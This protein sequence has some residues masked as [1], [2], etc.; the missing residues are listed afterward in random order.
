MVGTATSSFTVTAS[1]QTQASAATGT[2]DQPLAV[3]LQGTDTDGT[4]ASFVIVSLAAHGTLY[5]EAGFTTQ[6]QIGDTIVAAANAATVYFVPEQD[7]NGATSF[8]FAAVDDLGAQD[9]NPATADLTIA[10]VNDAPVVANIIPDQPS[11]P[12]A[13]WSFTIPAG[14]FTDVDNATLTYTAALANGNPLPGLLSFDAATHTFTG[15]PPRGF[16]GA[17]DI[18]VTVSDGFH[19]ASD[20]F[21]F[22]VPATSASPLDLSQ[23]PDSYHAGNTGE[24]ING[25]GG[26]D[27][28]TVGLGND[29]IDGGLGIDTAVF[30]GL[31]SA[32]TLTRAGNTLTVSGPDGIDMLTKIEKLAFDDVTIPSG[33]T[34]APTDFSADSFGDL[35]WQNDNGQ[36]HIWSMNSTAIASQLNAGGNPGPSWH[37]KASGDFNAD[38]MADILWQNDSGQ[39]A[40]WLMNGSTQVGGGTVGA[41]PGPAWHVKAAADFNG[42]GKADILWQNDNGQAHIWFMDGTNTV[43]QQNAGGSPGASWHI[44]DAADFNGDGKADILWQNDSGQAAIWLMNGST[45]VGGGTVGTNPGPAWHIKSAADFNGDGNADI[46]W[47]HDNGQAHIWFMNG[48]NITGQVN[49]GNNN[50]GPSWHVQDASDINGDGLADIVWQN[51][52]SQAAIWLMNGSSQIGGGTVGA[53]PGTDWH[54]IA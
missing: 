32:Y 24:T 50:P 26:S 51:D 31:R 20:N 47:Q 7:W 35:L 48:T 1:P 30:S 29:T 43:S 36:A 44:I 23:N 17:L 37:V 34:S 6:L 45:Q 33:L 2:E 15:T 46:L 12:D 19:S 27:I 40:I 10:A 16:A 8:Q 39:A 42:D 49:A 25:L 18:K 13:Y 3:S 54:I 9:A 52:N 38:G 14:S 53:N 11:A 28:I 22:L 21:W 5:R 41:N 4:I